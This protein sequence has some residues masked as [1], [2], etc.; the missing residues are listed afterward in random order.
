VARPE[1]PVLNFFALFKRYAASVGEK[2]LFLEFTHDT[3]ILGLIRAIIGYEGFKAIIGRHLIIP[4]LSVV[5]FRVR[6]GTIRM[7]FNDRELQLSRCY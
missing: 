5:R 1:S 6:D 4:F 2:K 3:F 7:F